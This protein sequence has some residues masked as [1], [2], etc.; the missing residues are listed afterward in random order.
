MNENIIERWNKNVHSDDIVYLLGDVIMGSI[1]K[2]KIIERLNGKIFL[3]IG[4]HDTDARLEAFSHLSNIKSIA[5]GYRYKD[6]KAT[7][8]LTHYPQ[9]TGNYDSS[10]TYSIHGHTHNLNPFDENYD[11]MYNVNCESQNCTPISFEEMKSQIIKKR[12]KSQDKNN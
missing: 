6:G 9:L 10:K 4:N 5:Y 12:N 1:D 3:A 11:L 2:I 7:F 8:L